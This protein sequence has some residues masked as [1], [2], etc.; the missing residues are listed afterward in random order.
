[1]HS[2]FNHAINFLFSVSCNNKEFQRTPQGNAL[3]AYPLA[4]EEHRLKSSAAKARELLAILQK[5]SDSLAKAGLSTGS[6]AIN[7]A[8]S[9]RT[10]DFR[11]SSDMDGGTVIVP[12][13]P[14]SPTRL[15]QAA[16]IAVDVGDDRSV[17]RHAF[18]SRLSFYGQTVPL[19][20][21]RRNSSP[22]GRHI[23]AA[24]Q[25]VQEGKVPSAQRGRTNTAEP[26]TGNAVDS[27]SPNKRAKAAAITPVSAAAGTHAARAPAAKPGAQSQWGAKRDAEVEDEHERGASLHSAEPAAEPGARR[28]GL[29]PSGTR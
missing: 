14:S 6:C 17:S 28:R 5:A 20:I 27:I 21:E 1:V 3:A 26:S 22:S 11:R 29:T 19:T 9:S 23:K 15:S 25:R 2:Q 16:R 12:G 13:P 7:A 8:G 24:L 4:A 10:L 18:A